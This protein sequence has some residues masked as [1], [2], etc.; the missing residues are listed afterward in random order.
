L[1]LLIYWFAL[2][3]KSGYHLP[4]TCSL[5]A[6]GQAVSIGREDVM[7]FLLMSGV[8]LVVVLIVPGLLKAEAIGSKSSILNADWLTDEDRF[9]IVAR[10]GA[11]H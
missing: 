2:G 9:R 1:I 7:M 5:Q 11:Q 8:L 10:W 6:N 3:F 4:A